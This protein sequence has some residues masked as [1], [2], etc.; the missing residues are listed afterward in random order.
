MITAIINAR[1]KSERLK[2]KH[3][4]KIGH[5]TIFEHI[6]D[7]LINT[8]LINEIYLATGSRNNNYK[9]ERF[10][11]SK[12]KNN[13]KFFYYNDE[14]DVTGRIFYLTKK[15]Q[16]KYSLLISGDCPLI[17][18]SFL[19]RLYNFIKKN[20]KKDFILPPKKIVHEGIKIFKTNAWQDVFLYSKRKIFK[21]NPGY[22]VKK[23]PHLFNTKKY[24]PL[25]YECNKKFRISVD[26][27]SDIEFLNYLYFRLRL[28]RK[29]FNI[30]NVLKLKNVK[31][32]NKHVLQR[33][34]GQKKFKIKIITSKDKSIGL[35]HYRRSQF[36]KREMSERY[37]CSVNVNI[38]NKSLINK[39]KKTDLETD[40]VIFDLD[41]NNLNKIK[42]FLNKKNYLVIDKFINKKSVNCLVPNIIINKRMSNINGGLDYLILDR[43]I[44]YINLTFKKEFKPIKKLLL[45]G[46]SYSIDPEISKFMDLNKREL[47]ILIGPL[48]NK[49][50]I[51]KLKKDNFHV[52]VNP[53]D[54]YTYIKSSENIYSRFG[55]SVFE[56]IALNKKPIVFSKYN[57]KDK[58][59]IYALY[60]KGYLNIFN[61]KKNYNKKNIDINYCYNKIDNFLIKK[62]FIEN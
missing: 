60:K 2:E 28:N 52:I 35:G 49:K 10:L 50:I 24:I 31:I 9:Y 22:I 51:K 18:R 8:N 57:F 15:I 12:Y 45:I 16:N 23:F 1:I 38:I 25:R 33:K 39:L 26:T 21:E 11:K 56:S 59:I 13:I 41:Q 34:P 5:K 3:L 53:R 48:V 37:Y 46:G 7:N 62:K 20:P 14:S 47:V 30:K 58:K 19:N 43:K 17:D 61:R 40:I 4:Y 32:L 54:I 6:I 55:I 36:L 27:K 44:N 29:Q 42:L